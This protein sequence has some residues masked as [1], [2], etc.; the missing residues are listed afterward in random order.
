MEQYKHV[1]QAPSKVG[2]TIQSMI[3]SPKGHLCPAAS[4]VLGVAC[5][6]CGMF[7]VEN[8][9]TAMHLN[10][11]K[12]K[13]EGLRAEWW[14]RGRLVPSAQADLAAGGNQRFINPLERQPVR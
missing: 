3:L 13:R 2:S 7:D 12:A 8:A 10:S 6:D 11:Y 9:F 14:H 1:G 4:L 5:R